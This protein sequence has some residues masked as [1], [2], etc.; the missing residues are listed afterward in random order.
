MNLSLQQA[1]GWADDTAQ[2]IG[3]LTSIN[4]YSG[5]QIN[6]I[7]VDIVKQ[8]KDVTKADNWLDY[9]YK[10]IINSTLLKVQELTTDKNIVDIAKKALT[11]KNILING[12]KSKSGTILDVLL[13]NS[14]SYKNIEDLANAIIKEISMANT[15]LKDILN[16]KSS[17]DSSSSTSSSSTSDSSKSS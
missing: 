5:M 14:Y 9:L 12:A 13:P 15:Y 8:Y 6:D 3:N 11:D 16:E 7:T 4:L 1:F 10:K 2:L 17:N